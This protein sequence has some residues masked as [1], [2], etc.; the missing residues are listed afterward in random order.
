[1][2]RTPLPGI[3]RGTIRQ[4][5]FLLNQ[6]MLPSFMRDGRVIMTTEK[7]APEFRSSTGDMPAFYP[8]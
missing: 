5:T 1:M 7:R 8:W 3:H 2:T 4:L 6:E